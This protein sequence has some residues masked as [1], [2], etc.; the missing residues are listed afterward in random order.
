MTIYLGVAM[1]EAIFRDIILAGGWHNFIWK[2]VAHF[3]SSGFVGLLVYWWISTTLMRLCSTI[4]FTLR[5][6]KAEFS[7]HSFSLLLAVSAGIVF[8]ILEDYIFD[9]F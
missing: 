5:L 8:H 3:V 7:I 6:W 9:I 2:P 4:P 1:I